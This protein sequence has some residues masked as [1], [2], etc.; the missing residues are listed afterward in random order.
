MADDVVEAMIRKFGSHFPFLEY[1]WHGGE[2]T[3]AGIDFYRRALAAQT[4]FYG[5]DTSRYRNNIQTN[6]IGFDDE[7]MDFVRAGKIAL[8]LSH[9]G[10]ASVGTR[11]SRSG[12]PIADKVEGTIDRL[13]ERHDFHPGVLCVVTRANARDPDGL[14]SYFKAQR[15]GA[16]SLLPHLGAEPEL[17]LTPDLYGSFFTRMFDLWMDDPDGQ[18]ERLG[19]FDHVMAKIL[20]LPRSICSWDAGCFRDLLSI[21]P[22]GGVYLCSAFQGDDHRLGNILTDSVAD[23]LDSPN[24]HAARAAQ[25]KALAECEGCDV[26]DVC[27]GGCREASFFSFGEIGR[28][29]PHCEGR[30]I[31][32]KHV[33]GRLLDKAR[34]FSQGEV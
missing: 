8:G 34:H 12:K 19:P 14:Y 30:R 26:L 33:A 25:E 21:E 13:I 5:D 7:W 23:I 10:P 27:S 1:S 4:A 16:L 20:G 6:G 18:I 17:R 24:L 28:R 11:V 3:M 31:L 9:D 2:P 15:V 22:D 29:D 32:V